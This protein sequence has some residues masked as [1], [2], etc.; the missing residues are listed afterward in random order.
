[1]S[2]NIYTKINKRNKSEVNFIKYYVL[3]IFDFL[4]KYIKGI[5]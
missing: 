4:T 5:I 2:Y 3:D 1:M